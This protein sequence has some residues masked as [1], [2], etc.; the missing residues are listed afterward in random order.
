MKS[1]TLANINTRQHQTITTSYIT[2]KAIYWA[3][4]VVLEKANLF[5]QVF[6]TGNC[7]GLKNI[8][9]D[10]QI[11]KEAKKRITQEVM[12]DLTRISKLG[13]KCLPTYQKYLTVISLRT[14]NIKKELDIVRKGVIQHNHTQSKWASLLGKLYSNTRLATDVDISVLS[15]RI[16]SAGIAVSYMYGMPS[17]LTNSLTEAENSDLWSFSGTNSAPLLKVWNHSLKMVN[18]PTMGAKVIGGYLDVLPH[19]II[20]KEVLDTL[21]KLE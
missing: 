13:E 6:N 14:S 11:F 9:M 3:T 12:D 8:D 1:L 17:K 2:S 10:M 5:T 20:S 15:S 21:A 4:K 16:G 7:E 19:V 18:K